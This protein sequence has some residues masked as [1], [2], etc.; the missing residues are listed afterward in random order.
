MARKLSY[1]T[2]FLPLAVLAFSG[3]QC[4]D[5]LE[6]TKLT[7]STHSIVLTPDEPSARFG[8]SN[9]GVGELTWS[10]ETDDDSLSLSR[11]AGTGGAQVTVTTTDFTRRTSEL[12]VNSLGILIQRSQIVC[13]WVSR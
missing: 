2:L 7:V 8:I 12:I 1:V 9:L 6:L 11:V 4:L 3:A 10:I 5:L 13:L